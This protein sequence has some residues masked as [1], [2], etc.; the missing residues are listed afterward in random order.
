MKS[1]LNNKEWKQFQDL[2]V[3]ANEEQL[4]KML[5][6]ADKEYKRREK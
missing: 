6:L 1:G 2:L 3:K 5:H 4:L